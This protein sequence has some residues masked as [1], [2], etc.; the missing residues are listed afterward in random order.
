MKALVILRFNSYLF[1]FE[2]NSPDSKYKL[3]SSEGRNKH[4]KSTSE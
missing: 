2:L 1:A 3:S 4:T